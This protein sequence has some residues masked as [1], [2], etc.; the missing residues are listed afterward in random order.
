MEGTPVSFGSISTASRSA[1]AKALKQVDHVVGI[2]AVRVGQ[3]KGELRVRRHGTE[4]LLGQL[5][6]EPGDRDRRKVGGEAAIRTAGYVDRAVGERLV[7]RQL[8]VRVTPDSGTVAEGRVERL[9]EG[10]AD[11]LD[12]VVRT[13]LEIAVGLDR[14]AEPTV[15]AHEVEHVVEEADA[16]VRGHGTAVEIERQGDRRLVGAALDR[17]R[18]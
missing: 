4:E 13:R 12:G 8:H 17:C 14:E 11:V 16:G 9:A 15:T 5:D 7:H 1:R 18:A 6:L 3:V 2:R 10:D